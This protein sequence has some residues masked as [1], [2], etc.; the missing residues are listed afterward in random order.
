MQRVDE[1]ADGDVVVILP[2]FVS[3]VSLG[4]N[5]HV[6]NL[7]IEHLA[8]AIDHFDVKSD[9]LTVSVEIGKRQR[10]R[11]EPYSNDAAVGNSFEMRLP[12]H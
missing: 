3:D 9:K 8:Q 10:I 6:L 1:P 4:Q 12:L 5:G 2:H 7:D 11:V